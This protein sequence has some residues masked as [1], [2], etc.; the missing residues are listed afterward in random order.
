MQH[1]GHRHLYDDG[2]YHQRQRQQQGKTY[3]TSLHHQVDVILRQHTDLLHE[4]FL[5]MSCAKHTN[6]GAALGYVKML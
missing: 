5:T 2:Q 4:G 6:S 3:Q 1:H